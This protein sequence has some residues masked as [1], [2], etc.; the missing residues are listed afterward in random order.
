MKRE[1]LLK[2]LDDTSRVWDLIIIGGGATG[3]GAAVDAAS[4][5]FKVVLLEQADFTKSTS[6]KST[7]LAHGGVRY[8][9]QGDVG[10][11]VEALRERG[12]MKQNAPHLVKDQRFIIGNYQWWE[13]PF[14][15]MGLTMYDVLAGKRSLGHSKPLSKETVIKEIPGIATKG[16]RGG[17][18]YYD[19]QFDDSRMAINLMQT[20]IDHQGVPLNYIRVEGL[21]KNAAGKIKG[22]KA[23][24]MFTQKEY[25]IRGE[26]VINATGIFVDEVIRMD[27]PEAH[28]MVKPS[29][30]VHLVVD[31]SF[32][33]GETAIM[34]PKT[35]DGRVLFGVPWHDR[36]ILGTTDTPMDEF[37]LEPRALEEEIDFILKTAGQYLSRQPKRED[38]LCVYAGLRP[39]AAPSQDGDGKTKEISRRHKVEISDSGLLTITGGK[40]TTYRDMAEDIVNKAIEV[41]GLP[42]KECR[43]QTLKIHG[44]KENV[45]RSNYAYVYGSDYGEIKA[46]VNEDPELAR[47]LHSGLD[48][49]G[50]EVVW[51]VRKEMAMTVEDVLSRRLRALFMDARASIEMAPQVAALMAKEMGKDEIWQQN[52]VARYTELAKG[53]LLK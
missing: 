36:V 20:A 43:T 18:L 46:L 48:F 15:T 7:K 44:Y 32:L 45:D 37:T 40:W 30:G 53:Y 14:Y 27:A 38:V 52:E 28:P 33:G 11:V 2:Q 6:S 47:P 31:R 13:K 8:L 17:V 34:I 39:L 3:L 1:D 10:L 51:G 16:L 35:S 26:A 9:A 12:L 22:V 4:R 42:K 21:I 41:A 29:Q 25:E 5:G 19:G 23:R 50:A 24:D 49:I